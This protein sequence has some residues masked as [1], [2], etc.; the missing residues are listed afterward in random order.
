MNV[1]ATDG[2]EY[3]GQNVGYLN[4][5]YTATGT[6]TSQ[7][8][9]STAPVMLSGTEGKM[10][11][12]FPYTQGIDYTAVE[13]DIADQHDWMYGT[14]AYAV[15]DK[16]PSADVVLAHAQ[17]ALNI[18][19][20]RANSYTGEGLVEA[21]AITS[22]GLASTGTLDTRD[23]SWS[24]QA[25]ANTAI[26]IISAPFTLDGETLD[27][28]ENP[29]MFVPATD[30]TKDFT[31]SATVD[32]KAYNVGVAMNE[33][34]APGKMYQLNVKVTNTGLTVS[35][36]TLIDWNIDTTLPEGTL[37]PEQGTVQDSYAEYLKLIYKVED[38][39]NEIKLLNNSSAM[40]MSLRTRSA[41][42]FSID[43]IE[44][45]I[46]DGESVEPVYNYQFANE[47]LHTVYIKFT[48][49]TQ[50]PKSKFAVCESMQ[51]ITIPESVTSIGESAFDRCWG[52]TEIVIPNS[53]KTIGYEG[54]YLCTG[55]KSVTIGSGVTTIEERAFYECRGVESI[56]SLAS[57]APSIESYT[58][59]NVKTNGTLYM[60]QGATGYDEW[61]S[62]DNYYLGFYN[63][64]KTSIISF[65]VGDE[66]FQAEEGMTFEQWVDSDYNIH[67]WEFVYV[68]GNQME[69]LCVAVQDEQQFIIV[70][71]EN[72]ICMKE[73]VIGHGDEYETTT[74]YNYEPV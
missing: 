60:P 51:E 5:A 26:N 47:G 25:G 38:T 20:V 30:E 21:L 6:G 19:V 2:G 14:E 70:E 50:I 23:G 61:L 65:S 37:Q 3:D 63:W 13:V 16:A 4:V 53:V 56:T 46:I 34:F 17:T 59:Y 1:T 39:S 67:G 48:D 44:E 54:F 68:I 35:K 43:M 45:L 42:V 9:G 11:A 28:Q 32:G 69:C 8:W 22:E 10:Y 73:D 72:G 36:V 15:S 52:L 41:E 18:N 58:F 31:V 57:T 66:T 64:N 33:A 29:Y 24:A 62:S 27:S 12:Y 40:P 74:G 55:L 7:T 71:G 49:M